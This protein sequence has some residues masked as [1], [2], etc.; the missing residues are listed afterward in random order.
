MVCPS[1]A[2][3]PVGTDVEYHINI[4]GPPIASRFR[5][6]DAEKLAA[7]KAEFL[8]LEKDRQP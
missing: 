2:L 7:A 3:P 1:K 6:L 8:Q 5:R 4:S